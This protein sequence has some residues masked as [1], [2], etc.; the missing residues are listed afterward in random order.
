[1]FVGAKNILKLHLDR[2]PSLTAIDQHGF[3]GLEKLF[4]LSCSHNIHLHR[5]DS[6]AF[7]VSKQY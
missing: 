7:K 3:A 2:M 4:Q 5:I 1:M 6:M